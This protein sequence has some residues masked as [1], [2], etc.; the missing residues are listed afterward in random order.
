[1]STTIEGSCSSCKFALGMDIG[2]PGIESS[3][4]MH[5][6]RGVEGRPDMVLICSRAF[7][8]NG[9]PEDPMTKVVALDASDYRAELWVTPDFGCVLYESSEK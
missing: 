8:E 3:H 4:A 6:A 5:G 9:G 2:D 1:M 7:G